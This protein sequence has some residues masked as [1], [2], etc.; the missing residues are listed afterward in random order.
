ME[1]TGAAAVPG[2]YRFCNS[3]IRHVR[4]LIS[5]QLGSEVFD[6]FCNSGGLLPKDAMDGGSGDPVDFRQLA[7]AAAVLAIL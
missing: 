7:E 4:S 3:R 6:P 5:W 2:R 1:V